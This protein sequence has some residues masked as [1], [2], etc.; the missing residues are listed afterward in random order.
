[1]KAMLRALWT[2]LPQ[3]LLPGQSRAERERN[4][5]QKEQMQRETGRIGALGALRIAA[6]EAF[7]ALTLQ[8]SPEARAA[9]SRRKPR[10]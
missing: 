6:R 4:L 9:S 3:L 8:P 10:L 5:R 7:Y 2:L 1:M